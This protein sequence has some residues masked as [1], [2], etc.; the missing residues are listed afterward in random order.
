MKPDQQLEFAITCSV[1]FRNRIE[2]AEI[3]LAHTVTDVQT[4]SNR[5]SGGQYQEVMQ[6]L[7]ANKVRLSSKVIRIGKAA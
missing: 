2:G 1:R 6:L 4:A 3:D 5:H 7:N